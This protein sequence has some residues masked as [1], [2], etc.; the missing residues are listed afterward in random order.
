LRERQRDDER[1]GDVS[2]GVEGV[3]EKEGASGQRGV[4]WAT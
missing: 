1:A 3:L 2:G 4:G